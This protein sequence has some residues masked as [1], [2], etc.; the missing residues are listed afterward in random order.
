MGRQ[1][2]KTSEKPGW[3][4]VKNLSD[5]GKR[6]I[7]DK[8]RIRL[9]PMQMIEPISE[10]FPAL[11]EQE[12]AFTYC[13]PTAKVVQVAGTFND[14]RPEANPLEHKGSGE[15]AARLMLKSGQYEYR[16]VVDGVWVDDPQATTAI[17][18]SPWRAQFGSACGIG[19]HDGSPVIE[20]FRGREACFSSPPGREPVPLRHLAPKAE[21]SAKCI[22]R[23][24]GRV[25]AF[26]Q[27]H[28]S[29]YAVIRLAVPPFT[30]PPPPSL[31][32]G[33]PS[34][35]PIRAQAAF[36]KWYLGPDSRALARRGLDA[37]SAADHLHA[38]AHSRQS[39]AVAPFSR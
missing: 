2:R 33:L 6:T 21:V 32:G 38:L 7:P 29:G 11:E 8:R 12:I 37:E 18:Q 27:T 16:F 39:E 30:A 1:L 36:A 10:R 31:D 3:A 28:P 15:W 23:V 9:K 24:A 34:A 17:K 13:A 14:W 4:T 26:G 20:V 19:R 25:G 5:R 35:R 22:P